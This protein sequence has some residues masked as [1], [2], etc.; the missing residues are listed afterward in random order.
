[1]D[2]IES[3]Y[4]ADNAIFPIYCYIGGI[5]RN[6]YLVPRYWLLTRSV[7]NL[8]KRVDLFRIRIYRTF[9][10]FKL[11]GGCTSLR[12]FSSLIS[13]MVPRISA[14]NWKS[15]DYWNANTLFWFFGKI[16]NIKIRMNLLL[17]SWLSH[18]SRYQSRWFSL[19][20]P[21]SSPAITSFITTISLYVT[22]LI[23][24]IFSYIL[25]HH[26]IDGKLDD[27]LF[28][29]SNGLLDVWIL[30]NVGSQSCFNQNKPSKHLSIFL[31]K[32]FGLMSS[33]QPQD[34]QTRWRAH[35]VL[36][37]TFGEYYHPIRSYIL[38]YLTE[39]F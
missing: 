39:N 32:L 3:F 30:N 13:V 38:L 24:M 1:M 5:S 11:M 20:V 12:R 22:Y 19:S 16:V 33:P 8:K 9:S 18:F 14:T 36:S 35:P 4:L 10:E 31:L 25:Y 29:H 21:P 7:T 2:L 17:K 34:F 15:Y 28:S 23:Y 27:F 26:C 6:Q 37:E